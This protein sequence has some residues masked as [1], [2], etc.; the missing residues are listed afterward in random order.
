VSSTEFN[1]ELKTVCTV[2][3]STIRLI[4]QLYNS[5]YNS[6]FQFR[7]TNSYLQIRLTIGLTILVDQNG[8]NDPSVRGATVPWSKAGV[9]CR[10]LRWWTLAESD[11]RMG[12][13]TRGK[14]GFWWHFSVDR[15]LHYGPIPGAHPGHIEPKLLVQ[16]VLY[17][18][19]PIY[20]CV[21]ARTR[22][23]TRNAFL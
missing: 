20:S 15:F 6:Y 19:A 11:A 10:D 1:T 12:R 16:V 17:L 9:S 7:L 22:V 21:L 23:S 8:R 13:I 4:I 18:L 3:D 14:D 5:A 2:R